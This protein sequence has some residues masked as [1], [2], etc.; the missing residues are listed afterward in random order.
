MTNITD[1]FNIKKREPESN[2]KLD[3]INE[4]N[5]QVEAECLLR[6]YNTTPLLILCTF[7]KRGNY[8]LK[9]IS[10]KNLLIILIG[11]I[12]GLNYFI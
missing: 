11:N 9:E 8:K 3:F 6:K 1:I 12:K 7:E 2:F 10:V 4:N 5:E